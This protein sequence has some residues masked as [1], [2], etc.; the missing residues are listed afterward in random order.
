MDSSWQKCSIPYLQ[1]RKYR[2]NNALCLERLRYI[3]SLKFLQTNFRQLL[4][5]A[6]NLSLTEHFQFQIHKIIPI[7]YNFINNENA[8]R[9]FY[10]HCSW[11]IRKTQK[12]TPEGGKAT[13]DL[14]TG[15]IGSRLRSPS[16]RVRQMN[17]TDQWINDIVF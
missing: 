15:H 3:M 4:I 7:T 16:G 12:A 1:M 10:F 2:K 13:Q 5:S 17:D 11:T 8:I 6:Q 14:R 9:Y